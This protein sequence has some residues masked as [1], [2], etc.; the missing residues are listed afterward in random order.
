MK[1]L[2]ETRRKEAV[3]LH[4][5]LEKTKAAMKE[6]E[7]QIEEQAARIAALEAQLEN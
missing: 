7:Q 4:I 2:L 5:N 3:D 6:K 1:A